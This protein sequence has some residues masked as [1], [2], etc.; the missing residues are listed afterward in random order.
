MALTREGARENR[1]DSFLSHHT[2]FGKKYS[3]Y[4]DNTTA[5]S[6]HH[7]KKTFQDLIQ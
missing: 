1:L 2:K 5:L 7:L 6:V 3:G 4:M